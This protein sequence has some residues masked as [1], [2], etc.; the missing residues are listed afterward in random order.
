MAEDPISVAERTGGFNGIYGYGKFDADKPDTI[1]KGFRP[2]QPVIKP[3]VKWKMEQRPGVP[4][5]KFPSC[6]GK[7]ITQ[8]KINVEYVKSHQNGY[9]TVTSGVINGPYQPIVSFDKNFNKDKEVES[10]KDKSTHPAPTLEKTNKEYSRFKS[11]FQAYTDG[12]LTGAKP[13]MTAGFTQE[14]SNP[15]LAD[16]DGMGGMRSGFKSLQPVTKY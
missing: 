3:E 1:D 9:K 7:E 2:S 12:N 15:K 14:V 13:V 16:G 10:N 6:G 4:V 8:N 5:E 11:G